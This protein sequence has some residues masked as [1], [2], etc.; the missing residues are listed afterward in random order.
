M[1]PVTR[2]QFQ[3]GTFHMPIHRARRDV[4]MAGDFLGGQAAGDIF[5]YFQLPSREQGVLIQGE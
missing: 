5:Q 3:S 4:D 1:C 2:A